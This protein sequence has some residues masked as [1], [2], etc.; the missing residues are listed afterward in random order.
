MSFSFDGTQFEMIQPDLMTPGEID[1]VERVT[2][3]TFQKISRLG[4]TCVCEHA[5]VVHAQVA[6]DAVKCG[7]CDCDQF[8]PDMPTRVSSAFTWVSL[9][10]VKPDARFE[11]IA[12]APLSTL[13][14]D[15]ESPADPTPPPPPSAEA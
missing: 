14:I 3:L 7:G 10:R 5:R 1:A 15:A 8:E 12:D 11:D 13:H 6:E 2:G 4:Q 9:K